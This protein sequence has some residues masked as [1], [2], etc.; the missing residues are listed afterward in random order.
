MKK[1]RIHI[2]GT[3][4]EVLVEEIKDITPTGGEVPIA[5]SKPKA[6]TPIPAVR[7]NNLS[8][9]AMVPK[10]MG[11]GHITAPMPGVVLGIKVNVGDKV[12]AGSLL[13]ILEAMKMENEIHAPKNGIVTEIYVQQGQTVIPGEL[14]INIE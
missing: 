11:G 1:L 4:Y 13:L 10:P 5:A 7:T 14:L 3:A 12:E 2:K 6:P 9:P 8:T